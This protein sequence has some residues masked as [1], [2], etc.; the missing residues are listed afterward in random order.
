M[1]RYGNKGDQRT[2]AVGIRTLW[3]LPDREYSSD[4]TAAVDY[5]VTT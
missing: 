5:A 2:D 3:R 1:T 4:D